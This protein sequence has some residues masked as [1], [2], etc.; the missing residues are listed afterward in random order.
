MRWGRCVQSGTGATGGG[1]MSRRSS[2]IVRR[3]NPRSSG[4]NISRQR[5]CGARSLVWSADTLRLTHAGGAARS[6]ERTAIAP[7]GLLIEVRSTANAS[8]ACSA[9]HCAIIPETFHCKVDQAR[10]RCPPWAAPQA[11]ADIPGET[12]RDRVRGRARPMRAGTPQDRYVLLLRRARTQCA[13][14][15]EHERHQ[16]HQ[17][18]AEHIAANPRAGRRVRTAESLRR[19]PHEQGVCDAE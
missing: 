18:I 14:P 4:R 5:R 17:D 9:D 8:P 7:R 19:R 6:M 12:A 3:F 16:I 10:S 2:P 11:G 1:R 15:Q 13:H